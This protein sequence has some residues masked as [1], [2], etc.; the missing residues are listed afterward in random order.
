MTESF[1]FCSQ[2]QL[3]QEHFHLDTLKT[4]CKFLSY[5]H[6]EVLHQSI[7]AMYTLDHTEVYKGRTTTPVPQD[8]EKKWG[9]LEES[10]RAE[11]SSSHICAEGSTNLTGKVQEERYKNKKHCR[12]SAG[13]QS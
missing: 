11:I 12:S 2:L 4:E 7:T 13:G 5:S 9:L 8:M 3:H 1:F 6:V 10:D